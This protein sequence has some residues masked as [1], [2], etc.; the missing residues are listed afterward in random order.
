MTFLLF[1]RL[2]LG[3]IGSGLWLLSMTIGAMTGTENLDRFFGEFKTLRAEFSQVVLDENLVS[4]EESSGRFWIARPGQF[5]WDYNSPFKQQIVADGSRIWVYD[6]ELEQVTV[7]NQESTLEHTPAMLLSGSGDVTSNY[8]VEDLG[9]Q[10][11][12]DW[13]SL[14]SRSSGSNFSE[15]QLGFENDTLKLIQLLDQLDRVTRIVLSRVEKNPSIPADLFSFKVP[16]GVDLIE[17][18]F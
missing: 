3:F 15:V 1:K 8:T 14:R 9:R 12:I 17:D 16:T 6:I 11:S 10:G 2:Y 13:V 18:S 5:R 4:L 7:R